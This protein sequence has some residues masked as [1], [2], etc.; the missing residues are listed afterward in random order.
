M[1]KYRE[2]EFDLVFP[3][4]LSYLTV[5]NTKIY[6]KN[7]VLYVYTD[8]IKLTCLKNI[9]LIDLSGTQTKTFLNKNT[10]HTYY[11]SKSSGVL[12]VLIY[13]I[14]LNYSR[15]FTQPIWEWYER[16]F[17]EQSRFS[18]ISLFDTRNLLQSY[19]LRLLNEEEVKPINYPWVFTDNT[20]KK[21]QIT[22][23]FRIIL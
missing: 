8:Q 21:L 12:S 3:L 16:E 22:N 7:T 9:K 15:S 14:S 13:G 19:T 17:L 5:S 11:N 4:L 23:S 2:S 18:F 10:L 6:Y 1:F 20:N